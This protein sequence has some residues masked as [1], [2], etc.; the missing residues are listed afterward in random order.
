MQ[1]RGYVQDSAIT[2]AAYIPTQAMRAL[3]RCLHGMAESQHEDHHAPP[4]RRPR[5]PAVAARSEAR[6]TRRSAALMD[7]PARSFW[8]T[9]APARARSAT[10]SLACSAAPALPRAPTTA[11]SSC[12]T[13]GQP[14]VAA[15]WGAR[16]HAHP[17]L[18]AAA[19]ASCRY[20]EA[21][22]GLLSV[23]APVP[24]LWRRRGVCGEQTSDRAMRGQT[25]RARAAGS[26]VWTCAHVCRHTCA[27]CSG[28]KAVLSGAGTLC[29]PAATGDSTTAWPSAP[30]APLAPLRPGSPTG[31][32][33]PGAPCSPGAPGTPG[34][35][36]LPTAPGRPMV[37][38][39]PCSPTGPGS[40]IAPLTPG[41]PTRPG[42]P[43]APGG[44]SMPL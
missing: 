32:G 25:S 21:H 22:T 29:P 10:P 33:A 35:P 11:C 5:R 8:P 15:A 13:H 23:L 42:I 1:R 36:V 38:G 12:W 44:P 43:R 28:V 31:P 27:Y 16:A 24:V 6:T 7:S 26:I 2:R 37:P 9:R 3:P 20:W 34:R 4:T 40:P 39:G 41:R 14:R 19:M 17:A 30:S 18:C